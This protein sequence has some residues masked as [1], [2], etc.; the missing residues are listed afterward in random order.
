MPTACVDTNIWFYA[1]A[2]PAEGEQA[3]H[4]GA[5]E[6]I[7]GLEQPIIITPQII[8]ELGANLLRKRAWI[9]P[10]LRTLTSDLLSR[11][12]LFIPGADWHEEASRLREGHRLSFWD[13]LVVV[14]AQAAGC[15]TLFSEDMHQ[16][17]RLGSLDI[18]NPFAG[19]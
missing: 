17:L 11:C 19:A 3:K 16:G 7:G 1:L 18:L 15:E 13:S 14:S 4:L 8:N 12:R 6:L 10:E 5:R 9:E 2:R